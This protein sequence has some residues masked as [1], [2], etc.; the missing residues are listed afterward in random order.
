MSGLIEQPQIALMGADRK[1]S[2]SRNELPFGELSVPSR[3]CM[4]LDSKG[5]GDP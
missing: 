5:D 4:K 3:L 1:G 2:M